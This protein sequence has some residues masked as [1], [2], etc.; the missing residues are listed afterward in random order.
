MLTKSWES[1]HFWVDPGI[2]LFAE[3]ILGLNFPGQ[4]LSVSALP[5][6]ASFKASLILEALKFS[7]F[8]EPFSQNKELSFCKLGNFWASQRYQN[9]MHSSFSA[10]ALLYSEAWRASLSPKPSHILKSN[11]LRQF[12]SY[13]VRLASS[14]T[15]ATSL[16]CVLTLKCLICGKELKWILISQLFSVWSHSNSKLA[17]AV[18]T[19]ISQWQASHLLSSVSP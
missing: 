8:L 3:T 13:W 2:V 7:N 12:L 16:N 17:P 6:S 19:L 4:V 14:P 5:I 1:S 18:L 11:T 10:N 15:S 9:S